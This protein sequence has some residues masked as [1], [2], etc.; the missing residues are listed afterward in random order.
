MSVFKRLKRGIKCT[1][2]QDDWK[3]C[4]CPRDEDYTII[5]Y[6]P[7]T[8]KKL[9]IPM[10]GATLEQCLQRERLERRERQGAQREEFLELV[11]GLRRRDDFARIGAVVKAYL[12]GDKILKQ[13]VYARRNVTDLYRVVAIAQDLWTLNEGGIRGVPRGAK[14]P[15]YARIDK[16]STKVLD[17]DLV[18][19]YYRTSLGGVLDWSDEREGNQSINSTL[20]HAQ[21]V[22]GGRSMKLLL[23]DLRLPDLSGFL[24][25]PTL[26]EPDLDPTPLTEAQFDAMLAARAM[27]QEEMRKINVIA[28]QTGMRPGSLAHLHTSWLRRRNDG[29][30]IDIPVGKTR[31]TLPVTDE[32]AEIVTEAKGFVIAGDDAARVRAL[33]NH[34]RWVKKV[35]GM[36]GKGQGTYLLRKTAACIVRTLHGQDVVRDFIGHEDRKSLKHYVQVNIHCSPAMR[37]EL[38]AA[39]RLVPGN[40]IEM[41]VM[42]A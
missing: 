27:A 13:S 40:V 38:R 37:H 33:A 10:P 17:F 31:Y 19:A 35:L 32:V 15:D 39:Q 28:T 2:G 5:T 20:G 24:T 26:Q 9:F 3:K 30:G 7:I 1:C 25:A 12:E 29:W 14:I 41:P 11:A 16:L 42:A 23:A 21:D 36:E 22:F 34:T 8:K 4:S 18:K 6:D